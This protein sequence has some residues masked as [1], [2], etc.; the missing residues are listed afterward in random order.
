MDY[1]PDYRRITRITAKPTKNTILHHRKT[2]MPTE[3]DVAPRYV[4]LI[5]NCYIP[6][7]RKWRRHFVLRK[8]GCLVPL[9]FL[10]PPPGLRIFL[11]NRLFLVRG[12][13]FF[14]PGLVLAVC[15]FLPTACCMLLVFLR[16]RQLFERRSPLNFWTVDGQKFAEPN[17][18]NRCPHFSPA[19]FGQL[20]PH[21]PRRSTCSS[22][23]PAPPKIQS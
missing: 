15:G 5:Q 8:F 23:P 16:H 19:P 18:Q 13:L 6:F 7:I 14:C 17:H 22:C 10:S 2:K 9:S 21:T 1:R 4:A 11:C 12:I 20:R 3:R